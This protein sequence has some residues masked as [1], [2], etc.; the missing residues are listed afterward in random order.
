MGQPNLL[1]ALKAKIGAGAVVVCGL[2]CLNPGIPYAQ[3]GSGSSFLSQE[4]MASVESVAAQA[5]KLRPQNLQNAG[6]ARQA[7][8]QDPE[9]E[10]RFPK[11]HCRPAGLDISRKYGAISVIIG[12]DR[13]CNAA[14]DPIV[15]IQFTF[16]EEGKRRTVYSL[17]WWYRAETPDEEKSTMVMLSCISRKQSEM[18]VDRIFPATKM[19][20]ERQEKDPEKIG[21]ELRQPVK[22]FLNSRWE[23]GQEPCDSDSAE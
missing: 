10:G 8:S 1:C 20:A 22:D 11:K 9:G 5:A 18:L 13:G 19:L 2:A 6:T 15:D 21:K 23:R 14:N 3:T 16:A 17:P 4:V 12:R 7:S